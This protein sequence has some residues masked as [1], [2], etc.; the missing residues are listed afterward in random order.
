MNLS[1]GTIIENKNSGQQYII[2]KKL[3]T[4]PQSKTYVVRNT[5]SGSTLP[6]SESYIEAFYREVEDYS[7]E[8]NALHIWLNTNN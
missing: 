8:F 1:K 2:L 4:P 3:N 7:E 5:E 6:I